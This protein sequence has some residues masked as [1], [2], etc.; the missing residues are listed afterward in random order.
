MRTS[1]VQHVLE[2]LK[3]EIHTQY[4]VGDLLPNE[5]ELAEKFDVSRNTVREAITFLEAYQLVEKTQRGARVRRPSFEPM[6]HILDDAFEPSARM[7]RDVLAFRRIVESGALPAVIANAKESDIV[8]MEQAIDRMHRALTVGEAAQ[9]DH[10]FHAA[11][12]NASGNEVLRQL[13]SV[14]SRT[15]IYYL[16]IGKTSSDDT[17]QTCIEHRGIVTALRNRS[18]PEISTALHTHFD[19]SENVRNREEPDA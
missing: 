15:L 18:L 10:D 12:V 4:R 16:E 6:F 1:A 13:Y 9:A 17:E 14:M 3:K 8:A 19:H 7:T 11:M 5:R 2:L